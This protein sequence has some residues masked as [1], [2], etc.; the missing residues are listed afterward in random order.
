MAIMRKTIAKAQD[1]G[2]VVRQAPTEDD[3]RDIADRLRNI[4]DGMFELMNDRRLTKEGYDQ[5]CLA[6][7]RLE[8]VRSK[9]DNDLLAQFDP[10][11]GS[12]DERRLLSVFYGVR[13][14]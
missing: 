5:M 1:D 7:T 14:R 6:K 2:T 12:E 11:Y 9:L 4:L 3:Y 10:P 13:E 8:H